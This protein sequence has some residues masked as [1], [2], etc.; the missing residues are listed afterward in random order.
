VF[1]SYYSRLETTIPQTPFFVTAPGPPHLVI[2]YL[3]EDGANAHTYGGEAFA[4]WNV[5]RRWRIAPSYSLIHIN[6]L[7]DLLLPNSTAEDV[8]GNS[9]K[10]QFGFRSTLGLRSDL[11]WDTSVYVVGRLSSAP[12]PSYTRLDI[13]LRWRL[14]K[15]LEF[16]AAGQNLLTARH[17]E[18]GSAYGVD[19]TQLQR[20]II[21]KLTW[22][23]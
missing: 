14:T 15:T 3:L 11:D 20:S 17:T 12:I 18:F 21:G 10:N 4:T 2:P 8:P 7:Q 13:Q 16:D 1:R 23:F 22:R 6:V 5:S 9:P 19:Y